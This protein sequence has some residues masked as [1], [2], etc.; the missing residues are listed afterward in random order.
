VTA[1]N[2]PS[3]G[4]S[5]IVATDI[6]QFVNALTGAAQ[7]G[8]TY[9]V[10]NST[11]ASIKLP[12]AA[13]A[14]KFKLLDSGGSEQ[15]AADSDGEVYFRTTVTTVSGILKHEFGGL[16]LNVAAIAEGGLIKGASTGAFEL[17]AKGAADQVLQMD[18]AGTDFSWTSDTNPKLQLIGA[19]VP[20]STGPFHYVPVWAN[21]SGAPTHCLVVD[22]L[23]TNTISVLEYRRSGNHWI[24]DGV[25]GRDHT[26]TLNFT[27]TSVDVPTFFAIDSPGTSDNRILFAAGNNNAG[28]DTYEVDSIDLADGEGLTAVAVT[29]A[30]SNQPTDTNLMG[31]VSTAISTTA[32]LTIY[33]DDGHTAVISGDEDGFTFTYTA[34]KVAAID[35]SIDVDTILAR[36]YSMYYIGTQL[37]L[38]RCRSL[39]TTPS[40]AGLSM[41]EMDSSFSLTTEFLDVDVGWGYGGYN[42]ISRLTGINGGWALASSLTQGGY[43][44]HGWMAVAFPLDSLVGNS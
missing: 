22:V 16:E 24:H 3:A 32:L 4:T 11:D 15:W 37:L 34:S 7:F 28:T 27:A 26:I 6:T 38:M 31:T 40:G 20:G 23:S 30:G 13:G 9:H 12:D 5:E 21:N 29:I 25:L 19:G 18:S 14:R 33:K 41:W 2:S 17:L 39:N 42:A 8:F 36:E 44:T 1:F 43:V 35:T 10:N